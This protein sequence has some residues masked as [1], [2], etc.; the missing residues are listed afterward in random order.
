MSPFC[1]H[2]GAPQI[3]VVVPD[4]APDS[5]K[6][7]PPPPAWYSAPSAYDPNAIRW[8]VAFK[9]AVISGL[10]AGLL[11]VTPVAQW[12]CLV[13][14]LGS[15]AFAVWF[16]QRRIPGAST[17]VGTGVRIGAIS[18]L[19]A[20][21]VSALFGVAGFVLRPDQFRTNLH[22][23]MDALTAA[24]SDP[25][26]QEIWR[27][28]MSNLDKPEVLAAYFVIGLFITA[29]LFVIV[30]AAGGAFGASIFRRRDLS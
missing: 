8:D 7:V 6:S 12:G 2:C 16:Y 4:E 10:G 24:N 13:W 23:Q 15:G 19:I 25:K 14:L 5:T 3:R 29:V 27:Q 9:G 30:S 1:P 18:G 26:M 11:S 22:E 20:F 28:M 21:L 17:T